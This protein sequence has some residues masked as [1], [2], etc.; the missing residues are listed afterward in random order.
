MGN[1]KRLFKKILTV[2]MMLL[3]IKLRWKLE[4]SHNITFQAKLYVF[5]ICIFISL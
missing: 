1:K 5:E 3:T 4:N 2:S